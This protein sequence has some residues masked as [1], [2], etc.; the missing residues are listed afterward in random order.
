MQIHAKY[1]LKKTLKLVYC[2]TFKI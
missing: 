1:C 2:A